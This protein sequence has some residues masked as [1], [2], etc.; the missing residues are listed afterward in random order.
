[1]FDTVAA[2]LGSIVVAGLAF[3]AAV[4]FFLIEMPWE[5]NLAAWVCVVALAGGAALL[6]YGVPRIAKRRPLLGDHA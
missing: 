3:G 6:K 1:L 2:G 4:T 5:R